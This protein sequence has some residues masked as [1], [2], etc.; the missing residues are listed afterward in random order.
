MTAID[1]AAGPLSEAEHRAQLR[2]AM[3]ASTV[4]TTIEWYDFLLYGTVT[5]LVFGKLYFP[6][7]SSLGRRA[8]SVRGFLRRLCRAADRRGDIRPL[9]RP[10][11]PQGDLDRDLAGDR[12]RDLCCRSGSDLRQHRHLG[13]GAADRHP[14]DPRDRGR[15]RMGR[16]GA[17]GDGMGANQQA[18]RLHLVLAAIRRAGRAVPRQSGGAGVQLAVRRPV[19]DLGLAHPVLHQHHHGRG[20]AVDPAR[21][22]RNPGVPE[23]PRRRPHRARAGVGGAQAPAQAGGADRAAAHAGAGAGLYRRRVHLHLRHRGARARR[24]TSC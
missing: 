4:G 1:A 14:L 16:L 13:C 18:S 5:A 11:R 2:R 10:H 3:I 7:S 6:H 20:R 22:F 23:D 12:R 21:H 9:R 19:P 24:A 8:R 15:R 17:A